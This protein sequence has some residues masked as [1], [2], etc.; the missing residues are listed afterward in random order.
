[1]KTEKINVNSPVESVPYGTTVIPENR[2]QYLIDK[3]AETL[4][5]NPGNVLEVGVYRGGTLL[6]LAE[7]VKKICPEYKVYGIDTFVGHPY[8]DGHAVHPVGKYADVT[9]DDMEEY[10]QKN[11]FAEWITLYQ[12]KVEEI[13]ESLHLTNISFAHIDCD[14]YVPVKYC[15]EN[16]KSIM[17]RPSVIYFD[18]YGHEHCPGATKAVEEVFEKKQIHIVHIPEDHT[19]WSGYIEL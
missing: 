16:V 3:C 6:A 8:S 1:M 17:S 13:L 12:G 10:I 14:L 4:A 19:C 15:A 11:G 9:K 2:L 5:K 7:V 18:D